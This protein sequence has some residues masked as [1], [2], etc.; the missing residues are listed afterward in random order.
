MRVIFYFAGSD[1]SIC[2]QK[3]ETDMKYT[4][5]LVYSTSLK[6]YLKRGLRDSDVKAI[7]TVEGMVEEDVRFCCSCSVGVCLGDWPEHIKTFYHQIQ[8]KFHKR[9]W[10]CCWYKNKFRKPH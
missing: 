3:I 2:Q 1:F 9:M 10:G 5:Y 6:T 7:N 4:E 8:L